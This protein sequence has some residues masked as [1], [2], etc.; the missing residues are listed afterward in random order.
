M[1]NPVQLDALYFVAPQLAVSEV[2]VLKA[3]GF[4]RVINNRPEA[5]SDDQPSGDNIRIA[6]ESLGMEYV[7]NPV[8]L[9]KLSQE[10]VDLQKRALLSDKKTLAF[11]RTGTRSSVLWVLLENSKGGDYDELF[12][13][14]SGKGFDLSRCVPAMAPL[15][16]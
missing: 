12:E 11:C 16:K 2:A 15:V 4:E 3:Q 14:V 8:D 13:L 5:E 10:Q 9:A 1:S 6:V 7:S